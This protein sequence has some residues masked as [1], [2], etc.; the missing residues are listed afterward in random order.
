MSTDAGARTVTVYVDNRLDGK[1]T[2]TVAEIAQG[3][4]SSAFSDP[5][6]YPWPRERS[7]GIY[8][9]SKPED[10]GLSVTVEPDD[11][12][13]LDLLDLVMDLQPDEPR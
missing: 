11:I 9:A 6:Q 4:W 5:E 7:F 1:K 12:N 13:Q 3:Y 2:L 8:L 10:G